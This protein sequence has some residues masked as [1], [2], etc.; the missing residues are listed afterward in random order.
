MWSEEKEKGFAI[1]WVQSEEKNSICLS[2][3]I[4]H[5]QDKFDI[6][7]NETFFGATTMEFCLYSNKWIS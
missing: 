5:T 7:S 2:K 4:K 1:V 6:F 3:N